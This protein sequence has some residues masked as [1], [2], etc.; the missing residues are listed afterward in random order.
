MMA[1][2]RRILFAPTL[3]RSHLIQPNVTHPKQ[4][5]VDEK[6]TNGLS[7]QNYESAALTVELWARESTQN[8]VIEGLGCI[9]NVAWVGNRK[10]RSTATKSCWIKERYGWERQNTSCAS[11]TDSARY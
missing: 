5:Q 11:L 7:S 10:Q 1:D 8:I 9:L 4:V 2:T 3:H 6:Y